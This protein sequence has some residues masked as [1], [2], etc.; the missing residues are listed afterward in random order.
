MMRILMPSKF[1]CKI[2]EIKIHWKNFLFNKALFL[3]ISSYERKL[4]PHGRLKMRGAEFRS[5]IPAM[6]K[7]L[8]SIKFPVKIQILMNEKTHL[9][10]F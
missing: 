6:R 5:Q 8:S 9:T 7:I 4:H 3:F 1:L 10:I 2:W